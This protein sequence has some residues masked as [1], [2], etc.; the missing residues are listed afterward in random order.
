MNRILLCG[1]VGFD[2]ISFIKKLFQIDKLDPKQ[3]TNGICENDKQSG[4]I[5][6][7]LELKTKYYHTEIGVF[8]DEPNTNEPE[9]YNAWLQELTSPEMKELRDELQFIILLFPSEAT[10][11]VDYIVETDKSLEMINR[12]LDNEHCELN[13]GSL[14]WDGEILA[15]NDDK[16]DNLHEIRHELD[17]VMWRNRIDSDNVI[18]KVSSQSS[19]VDNKM[20]K[21][22]KL[23]QFEHDLIR[24]RNARENNAG[25]NTVGGVLTMENKLLVER[26]LDNLLAED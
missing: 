9:A 5:I 17:C 22:D 2:K 10:S 16:Y 15:F 26:V 19:Q 13:E 14:Q 25:G 21:L 11:G 4:T 12:L 7:G 3:I 18:D 20:D 1:P 6:D 8:I 24:L 23:E